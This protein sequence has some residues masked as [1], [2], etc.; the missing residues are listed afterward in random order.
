L[1]CKRYRYTYSM[2]H[3]VDQKANSFYINKG[4]E[5]LVKRIYNRVIFDELDLR[6]DLKLNFHFSDDL[7][8]RMGRTSLGFRI[9]KFILPFLK[10]KIFHWN[11]LIKWTNWN[12]KDL[13]NYV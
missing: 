12:S 13:E 10:G 9:S 8:V 1:Y 11:H 4:T 2:H 6:T 5:I 3:R 7:D